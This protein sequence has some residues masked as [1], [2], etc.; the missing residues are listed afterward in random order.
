MRT[1]L[2]SFIITILVFCLL[3]GLVLKAFG[4]AF[5][6]PSWTYWL[7]DALFSALAIFSGSIL[8]VGSLAPANFAKKL[9]SFDKNLSEVSV[10]KRAAMIILGV[11]WIVIGILG[12]VNLIGNPP[13]G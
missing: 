10:F 3:T 5:D 12:L 6:W 8:S 4:M 1:F 11:I 2:L 9:Y 13:I 7:G